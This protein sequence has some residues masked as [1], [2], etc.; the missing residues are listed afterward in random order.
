MNVIVLPVNMQ[1]KY[2][3]LCTNTGKINDFIGE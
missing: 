1:L 3:I 2:Y